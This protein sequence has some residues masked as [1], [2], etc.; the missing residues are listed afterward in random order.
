M[1]ATALATSVTT[2]PGRGHAAVGVDLEGRAEVVAAEPGI[3]VVHPSQVPELS[4]DL[5]QAF[6]RAVLEEHAD[7]RRVV[8]HPELAAW[9]QRERADDENRTLMVERRVRQ[10]RREIR[11]PPDRG[12][13]RRDADGEA[14][15]QDRKRSLHGSRAA[16]SGACAARDPQTLHDCSARSSGGRRAR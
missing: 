7:G 4:A 8:L 12:R 13:L 2:W 11:G 10:E 15:D 14:D 5:A 1:G 9:R 16:F 3:V 6:G